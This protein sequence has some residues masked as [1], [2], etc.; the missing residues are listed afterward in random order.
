MNDLVETLWREFA[1]ETEEHLATLERLLAADRPAGEAV[2]QL[3]RSMHSLKGLARAME[4]RSLEQV[5]HRAEDLLG[6]V[7]EGRTPLD[8]PLAGLLLDAVDALAA[9]RRSAVEERRDAPLPT[10]LAERLVTAHLRL[11]EGGNRTPPA[12]AAAPAVAP[13]HDDEEML[14]FFASLV[15]EALPAALAPLAEEGAGDDTGPAAAGEAWEGIAQAAEGMGFDRLAELAAAAATEVAAAPSAAERRQRLL[16]LL[17]EVK[18]SLALIEDAA[19]VASGAALMAERLGAAL[20]DDGAALLDRLL[21]RLAAA[22]PAGEAVGGEAVERQAA[23]IAA[24]LDELV[25]LLGLTRHGARLD[26]WYLLADAFRQVA[27][28]GALLHRRLATAT[29]EGARLAREL[30]QP[31]PH[32]EPLAAAARLAARLRDQLLGGGE[33]EEEEERAAAEQEVPAELGIRPE[34]LAILT[35]EQRRRVREATAAGARPYE[36][37]AFLD[38]SPEATAAFVGWL[39]DSG[40]TITNRTVIVGTES[41]FEFLFLSPLE[42]AAVA[43]ALAAIDPGGALLQLRVCGGQA[44]PAAAEGS[45]ERPAAEPLGRGDTIRLPS[46]ALDRFLDRLGEALLG[47]G[48][49]AHAL[50]GDG[51]RD[52]LATL[53]ELAEGE[54]RSGTDRLGGLA[55]RLGGEI[56]RIEEVGE[57][58]FSALDRLQEELLALRVVPIDGL[59]NRLPRLVR[60]LARELGKEVRLEIDGWGVRIDKGLVEAL[61]DPLLHMVRNSIDHGIEPPGARRAAGKPEQGTIRLRAAQRGNRVTLE[62]SDDGRGLDTGRIRAKAVR[63]GLL[64]EAEAARLLA[65]QLHELIFTPGFS[66]AAAVTTTSGR[67]VGMDVV[68]ATLTRLGGSISLQSHFG[69]GTTFRLHLPPSAAVQEGL[70]VEAAGQRLALP[71]RYVTEVVEAPAEELR[72]LGRHRALSWRGGLLPVVPLAPLL[73]LGAAP[74]AAPELLL[75]V[76]GNGDYRVGL[77]VE[78]VLRREALFL[79]E[80]H[81]HLA[82]L[83]GVGGVSIHGDGRV[84]LLLDGEELLRMAT[85]GRAGA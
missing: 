73:G 84:V 7:R 53:H 23:A 31:G 35:A 3:F 69:A 66:T 82:T 44:A 83:P 76:L 55:A 25:R 20:G 13:L 10:A 80:L 18:E 14:R 30:W 58:L 29:R 15:V 47:R 70:M 81:P 51:L 78:R 77:Q 12:P 52:T 11:A 43:A 19:G 4:M 54:A 75:V 85:K 28:G 27:A 79:K 36:I 56:R 39:G 71:D 74:A 48:M 49:L 22:A 64:G 37:T 38:S 40:E 17:A 6:L 68:R 41:R 8:A 67:G 57:R 34:L 63:L 59:F 45:G 24:A 5:A 65:A 61:A 2:A 16:P 33:E 9:L 60:E 1:A 26:L 62:L 72:E 21:E 46:A 32:D 50:H 42:P